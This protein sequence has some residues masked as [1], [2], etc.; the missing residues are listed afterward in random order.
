[1]KKD[2]FNGLIFNGESIKMTLR[3]NGKIRFMRF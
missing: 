1:M 2:G 3:L